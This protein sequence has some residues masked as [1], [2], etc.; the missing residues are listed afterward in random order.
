MA[1]V[2][3]AR[4]HTGTIQIHHLC[5]SPKTYSFSGL[6]TGIIQSFFSSLPRDPYRKSVVREMAHTFV[7]RRV[8]KRVSGVWGLFFFN[9]LI[10][11]F[12]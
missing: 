12:F 7:S 8:H 1:L 10:L 5:G 2:V 9:F 3:V 6:G 4:L 11:F